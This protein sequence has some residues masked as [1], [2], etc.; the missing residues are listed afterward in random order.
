MNVYIVYLQLYGGYI[1]SFSS[2]AKSVLDSRI[3][4]TQQ[5]R[6]TNSTFRIKTAVWIGLQ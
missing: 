3:W 5:Q 4:R 6:L 2:F 1:T